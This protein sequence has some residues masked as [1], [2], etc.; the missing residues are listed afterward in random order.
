MAKIAPV[1]AIPG[2]DDFWS[3]I[4]FLDDKKARADYL[5]Q[6]Q[7][8]KAEIDVLIDKAGGAERIDTLLVQAQGDRNM[9]AETLK[10][11]QEQAETL[12]RE[13]RAEMDKA[14]DDVFKAQGEVAQAK[15]TLDAKRREWELEQVTRERAAEE[16]LRTAA[17]R[18]A[19]ADALQARAQAVREEFEGKLRRLNAGL[20]AV[21]G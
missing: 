18:I 2:V 9:A 12:R 15:L 14:A 10:N 17:T 6:V 21:T 7:T 20:A 4:A 19:Q 13:T 11:A 5:K 3:L 16:A 1:P 8:L